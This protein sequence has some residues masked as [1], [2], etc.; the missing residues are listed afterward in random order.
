MTDRRG[1]REVLIEFQ[2]IGNV[3]KVTAVDLDTLSEVSI[4]GPPSAGQGMIKR[5]VI[6]KLNYALS[7][8]YKQK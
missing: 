6:N 5:N 7:N 8:K 4:M 2:Q 3:V 1:G